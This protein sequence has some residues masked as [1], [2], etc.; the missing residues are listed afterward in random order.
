VNL[1]V[2]HVRKL[3]DLSKPGRREKPAWMHLM[4]MRRRKTLITCRRCHED[5]HAGRGNQALPEMITGE[6]GAGKLASPVR[7]ETDGKGPGQGHLAGGRLHSA[8]GLGKRPGSNHGTALQADSTSHDGCGTDQQPVVRPGQA[9]SSP[10]SLRGLTILGRSW[11]RTQAG[12]QACG[13]PF[14]SL[15][16]I[17]EPH[18]SGRRDPA[19]AE[20]NG[21]RQARPVTCLLRGSLRQDGRCPRT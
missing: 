1:E 7:E 14:R 13:Q 21:E 11:A 17:R 20:R 10:F 19:W 8:S 3:A 9:L 18:A 4:A 12:A 5:I 15:H 2:H 6:Q 16:R